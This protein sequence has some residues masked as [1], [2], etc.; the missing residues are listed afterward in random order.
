MYQVRKDAE[1][2]TRKNHLHLPTGIYTYTLTHNMPSAHRHPLLPHQ[3]E[4]YSTAPPHIPL[5]HRQTRM[6]QP[7]PHPQDTTH[8]LDIQPSNKHKAHKHHTHHTQ[9]PH[10]LTLKQS[11]CPQPHITYTLPNTQ[12]TTTSQPHKQHT[13]T[14]TAPTDIPLDLEIT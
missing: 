8:H 11:P 1:Y 6:P 5:R 7:S 4:T 14:H 3:R 9:T 13:H 12:Q 2:R 10:S